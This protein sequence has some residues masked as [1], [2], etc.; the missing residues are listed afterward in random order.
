MTLSAQGM[1]NGFPS[2][3]MITIRLSYLNKTLS[4]G[5]G[6]SHISHNVVAAKTVDAADVERHSK[7]VYDWWDPNGSMKGLHTLN[8]IRVPLIRDGLVSC[9]LNERTPLPLSNKVILDVG[10]GGGI[11]TEAIARLGAKVTGVDASKELI[12]LA[13][14]HS[15]LDPKLA[16]NTPSYECTTIEEH[17]SLFTDH[18][19]AVVASEIIE[20]VNN[21]EMFIESC[22]KALKPGGKIFITTP[23]RTRLMHIF[24]IIIAE[25]I[26]KILPQGTHEYDKLITPN[27]V[28]FMLEKNNCH[29]QLIHGMMYDPILNKWAWCSSTLFTYALQA[30]KLE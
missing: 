7:Q 10:C 17:S 18:Y 30:V 1:V 24:G 21:K 16:N 6:T 15:S 23:N 28:T 14:N 11:L 26:L 22:V 13:K 5:I 8:F 19:D 20:H 25:N 9:S 27:E 29:V 12:E 4:R 2:F 3:C